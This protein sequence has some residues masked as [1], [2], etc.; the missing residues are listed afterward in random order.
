MGF[1]IVFL[2]AIISF[3]IL[4]K[5]AQVTKI[6]LVLWLIL[7]GILFGSYGLYD[8]FGQIDAINEGVNELQ[9]VSGWAVILL[10]LMSGVGL[11][12]PAI[13]QSGKNAAAL[14]IIP[15]YIEGFIM[16]FVAYLLFLALPITDFKFSLPF[17]MMVMAV[18]AMASP[19]IIIPLCFKGK[20]VNPNGKIYDEMMIASIMDNFTPFPLLIIYLTLAISLASGDAL[21]FSSLLIGVLGSIVSLVVAYIIG[22]LIGL[23]VYQISKVESIPP[24]LIVILH[25]I[26]T[27]IAISLLGKLGASYGIMIGLGSGVGMNI[28]IKDATK[29]VKVLGMTQKLYGLLFMPTI[30]IY[31]GT[32]IQLDLLLNPIIILSLALITVIS[33]I[34][35]GFISN[36]YLLSQGYN[37]VDSKLSGSLFA[38]KGIILINISLIIAPALTNVGAENVLQY[39]YILAA[40]ATLIS[41]PYSIVKSEKLLEESKK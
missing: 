20:E 21:S 35:K 13:K 19:A 39:M 16:G 22:H 5:V 15:V 23:L 14:S 37:E 8:L 9:L 31:V 10:F 26:I 25:I 2:I 41:V 11:N 32:K 34:V 33:I 12:V 29:K 17:F 6:P 36:K 28:G 24:T 1:L 18:F 7:V 30:F 4:N 40:V 3:L 38:S 27:L